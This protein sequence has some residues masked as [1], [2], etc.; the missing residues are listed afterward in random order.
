MKKPLYIFLLCSLCF[1]S[2]VVLANDKGEI[3]TREIYLVRHAEKQPS[4]GKDPSLTETGK[5]RA[6]HLAELL[7]SR[8]ISAVYS[9]QYKRTLETATPLANQLNLK[10]QHYDP[11]K[12]KEFA[13]EIKNASGN[14]LIVGHSNTTPSL[15]FLLGGDPHGDI[16]D[17]Y[18]ERLYQL[19]FTGNKVATQLLKT[20][21]QVNRAK[22]GKIQ[23]NPERFF[24]GQLKYRMSMRGKPVGESTHYF[25]RQGNDFLL[26]EKTV[27]KDFNIDADINVVVDG[28]TFSPKKMEMKGSM[29]APVDIQLAWSDQQVRGHSLMSRAQFKTQGKIKVD[30]KLSPNV[31]ERTASIMLAHLVKLDKQKAFAVQWYNGYDNTTRDIEISYQGEE[32]VVVPA[33]TF[34]T[35]KIRYQG[36]A[37][38]Q[39]FYIAKGKQPKVVKIEVIAS[40]WLYELIE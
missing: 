10:V 13:E 28:K 31:V 18:Y 4:S 2:N 7:K 30:R 37:P 9:T 12:L 11:R 38:S 40:P 19:N 21:P 16:D 1:I 26:H 32:K 25:K 33:G 24:N 6:Q 34:D 27:L 20:K 39:L 8:S 5:K 35:Y 15:V 22:P 36:G 14:V 3:D 23:F 29:G 17:S